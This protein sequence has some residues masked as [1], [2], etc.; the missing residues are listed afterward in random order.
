MY[1]KSATAAEAAQFGLTLDEA[2]GPPIEVWPDNILAVNVF[3][4]MSTQW[5]TGAMGATGLDYNA[6]E[7][8]MRMMGIAV[9]GE[10]LEEI[11][12]LEDAALETMRKK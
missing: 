10:I 8:T 5:R 9:N 3:V 11:R 6:L 7:A 2:Q 1:S 12:I 4:S